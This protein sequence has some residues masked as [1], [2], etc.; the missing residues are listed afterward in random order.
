MDEID[1]YE[2]ID[3]IPY[4]KEM[5]YYKYGTDY[6]LET[7]NEP[8]D[9]DRTYYQVSLPRW[10]ELSGTY[11]P[12]Q[13]CTH[14]KDTDSYLISYDET[15]DSNVRYFNTAGRIIENTYYYLPGY[16][17]YYATYYQ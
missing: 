12:G 10:A 2:E 4:E 14:D 8:S 11:T 6:I 15:A 1:D 5:Y 13:Y 17:Y 7:G 3:L 9:Y 16:Y